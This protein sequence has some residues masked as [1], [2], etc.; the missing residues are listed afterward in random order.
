[1]ICLYCLPNKLQWKIVGNCKSKINKVCWRRDG[2]AFGI[3]RENDLEFRNV[4]SGKLLFY[5]TL[6]SEITY[7]DWL[8][9]RN[10]NHDSFD[11]VFCENIKKDYDI[12]EQ[13]VDALGNDDNFYTKIET[14]Y[15]N[16]LLGDYEKCFNIV[17]VGLE[18]GIIKLLPFGLFVLY[19]IDIS[20]CFDFNCSDLISFNIS[21]DHS[22]ADATVVFDSTLYQLTFDLSFI[23]S[24]KYVLR[25][26][27]IKISKIIILLE[28]VDLLMSNILAKYENIFDNVDLH[29][30][31]FADEKILKKE[32]SVL[33]DFIEL[34]ILG[35]ITSELEMLL[36]HRL[37]EE[38]LTLLLNKIDSTFSNLQNGFTSN[39]LCL[40]KAIYCHLNDIYNVSSLPD[41]KQFNICPEMI[42][43]IIENTGNHIFKINEF[44]T[45]L[46]NYQKPYVNFFLWLKH[47]VHIFTET[48]DATENCLEFGDY[49][50]IVKFICQMIPPKFGYNHVELKFDFISQYFQN[51]PLDSIICNDTNLKCNVFKELDMP[52]ECIGDGFIKSKR[53]IYDSIVTSLSRVVYELDKM[54]RNVETLIS[55]RNENSKFRIKIF[56]VSNENID[57]VVVK[58]VA[59]PEKCVI[60]AILNPD[61]NKT[62]S[63]LLI[64]NCGTHLEYQDVCL[65]INLRE[66]VPKMNILDFVFY[67]TDKFVVLHKFESNQSK[68]IKM[69]TLVHFK[70]DLFND[71]IDLP[72]SSD[73]FKDT[74]VCISPTKILIND[75]TNAYESKSHYLSN[76][77]EAKLS[78]VYFNLVRKNFYLVN[79][80]FTSISWFIEDVNLPH[81]D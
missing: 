13:L 37:N 58:S 66:F 27:S 46:S 67:S 48:V 21:C 34:I 24:S 49:D 33:N 32:G 11:G 52:S 53:N 26:L 35:E 71:W 62:G 47:Q 80:H 57:K 25:W 77:S 78:K 43:P 70:R 9:A 42:I 64:K 4:D 18:N 59:T 68:I 41:F 54:L 44:T 39:Y 1:M 28:R 55:K 31:K 22:F 63:I 14:D 45:R 2:R 51:K 5:R 65:S 23:S 15:Y 20:Q 29:M 17:V 56:I 74:R 76:D 19:S 16:I 3:G 75:E 38:I 12:H 60:K 50:K 72:I 81:T 79:S 30:N 7:L 10:G 73:D 8:P 61:T 69:L 36:C 40:I 6:N